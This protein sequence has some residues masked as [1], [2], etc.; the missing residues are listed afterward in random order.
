MVDLL[1]Y[2]PPPSVWLLVFVFVLI[3]LQEGVNG[4]HDTANAVTTVIYSNSLNPTQAISVSVVCNFFGVLIGGTAVAFSLVFLLPKEMV[5]GIS[6]VGEASL[7]L[8]LV[9]TAVGWNIATWWFGIP[10]STTH[11]YIGSIIGVSM[12]H[13]AIMGQPVLDGINW[14]EGEKVILTLFLSPVLGFLLALIFFR[15]IKGLLKNPAMFE[16]HKEGVVPPAGVRYPLIGGLVGVSLLHG[17]NDGQKSIGLLLMVLMGMMPGLYAID[18]VKDRASYEHALSVIED[19]E[20]VATTLAPNELLAPHASAIMEEL[21][22]IRDIAKR[23]FENR[24]LSEAEEIKFRAEI[25]DIHS[26]VGRT[27]KYADAL[28]ALSPE[29]RNKLKR[30][31]ESLNRLIEDVPFWLILLSSIA[32]G[33]GTGIGY[34]KI[35]ATLGSK[36]GGKA[37]SPAQGLA[38]QS[39]AV[40]AIAAG[41]VGGMPVS[42]THVLT[43]GV[44]GGV[45]GAR[46][47]LQWSTLR[48][49]IVTWFTTL[50]GCVMVSFAMG[51]VL[52]SALV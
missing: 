14:V 44:A 37:M 2:L 11:T 17:S 30:A 25:L 31:H 3:V 8:A 7:M 15:L 27:I 39:A 18:P 45:V 34:K 4:F 35:V 42:T 21:A 6:T 24:P 29:E 22:H 28:K 12:A 32:L 9:V 23:D 38:A 41:D 13:A 49:I 36:M 19:L 46:D 43:S 16:P 40:A 47:T 10:N 20:T 50:P 48:A 26:A 52:H 33:L 1:E 51:I 5:A